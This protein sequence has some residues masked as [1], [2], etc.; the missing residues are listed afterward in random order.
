L[1]RRCQRILD[2]RTSAHPWLYHPSGYESA[3]K[4]LPSP[5]QDKGQ[6]RVICLMYISFQR[7]RRTL[8]Q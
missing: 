1:K 8:K 5:G 2:V 6:P 7:S 4:Q 3:N